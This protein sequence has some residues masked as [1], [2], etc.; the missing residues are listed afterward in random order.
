MNLLNIRYACLALGY[1]DPISIE[2]DGTVWL[3][4]DDDR[5]YPP[6]EPIL[7]KAEEIAAEQAVKK[8]EAEAKLLELGLTVQDL[9]LLGL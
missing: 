3:G 4:A 9:R 1:K 6:M 5:T 8:K 7:A 2:V